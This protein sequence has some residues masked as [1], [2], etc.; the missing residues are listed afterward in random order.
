MISM[1]LQLLSLKDRP[2]HQ[3]SRSLLP[4]IVMC[5]AALI[6]IWLPQSA[7][8]QQ[9]VGFIVDVRGNWS[10][11]N[12]SSK[13]LARGQSLPARG[14]IRIQS[15]SEDDYIVITDLKGEPMIKRHCR[16]RDQCEGWITLPASA[17]KP[18]L[19]ASTYSA[20]MNLIWG[21]PDRYSAHRARDGELTDSVVELKGEQVD[22]SEVFRKIEKGEY[23]LRFRP[24]SRDTKEAANKRPG[25][26]V[27]NWQAAHPANV[28]IPALKPGLYELTLLER[29]DEMYTSTGITAWILVEPAAT[30]HQTSETYRAAVQLT[31]KWGDKVTPD[32]SR[33]FL[34]AQLDQLA[35]HATR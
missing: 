6:I 18:G 12:D 21:E 14:R 35:M 5:C 3:A 24:L 19:L 23:H 26:V 4:F 9:Q 33:G 10:L 7:L 20:V 27:F 32:A 22:L 13:A 25:P 1:S 31:G 8:A 34:R 16:M 28:S 29:M 2:L 30:F 15:P 17:E 11:S